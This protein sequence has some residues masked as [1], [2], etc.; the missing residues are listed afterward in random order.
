MSFLRGLMGS[1]D[2]PPGP[3]PAY[4][5]RAKAR[6]E[7]RVKQ[8]AEAKRIR[9]EHEREMM[10]IC[11]EFVKDESLK[12][13]HF[14]VMDA[15]QRSVTHE[16]CITYNISSMAFGEEVERRIVAFKKDAAPSEE[17]YEMMNRDLNYDECLADLK[18]RRDA[19]LRQKEWQKQSAADPNQKVKIS[20]KQAE[21]IKNAAQSEAA[22][23]VV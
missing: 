15:N 10:K 6:R 11:R 2:K 5:A 19:I 22:A 9:E 16:T 18:S 23:P 20:G 14:D 4:L 21:L 12:V 17:D 1:M 8:A 7:E 13:H 3:D